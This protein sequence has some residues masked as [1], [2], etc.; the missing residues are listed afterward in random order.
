[1]TL[2]EIRQ[3][4]IDDPANKWAKDLGYMPVYTAS[5]T[6]RIMIVG[7]A[8]GRKAQESLTPWNDVSGDNLRQWLELSREEFYNPM[9]IALVPMDF[10]YPGK[11]THGD[12]PPRKDFA[13]RWHPLILKEMPNIKLIL[14]VGAYAQKYYLNK[15]VQRNLTETVRAFNTYLPL[16]IPFVHPSPLNF[17]WRSQNP[18]FEKEVVPIAQQLVQ[19]IL[20]K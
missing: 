3:A 19:E 4:I 11:G 10:Y 5:E 16:Y 12:L 13:A 6:A 20:T 14:L 2:A 9:H 1:M 7:Q 15:K 18:W 8:P 17:R